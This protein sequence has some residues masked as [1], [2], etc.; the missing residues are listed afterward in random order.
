MEE[1]FIRL[2]GEWMTP[3]R[4]FLSALFLLPASMMSAHAQLDADAIMW[5]DH[6]NRELVSPDMY[7]GVLLEMHQ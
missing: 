3:R 7:R 5:A 4:R 6:A 2:T 1:H